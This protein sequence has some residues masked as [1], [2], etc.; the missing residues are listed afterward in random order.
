MN[1]NRILITPNYTDL[2]ISECPINCDT[3]EQIWKNEVFYLKI[4][5][6]CKKCN[7]K[8]NIVLDEPYKPSNTHCRNRILNQTADADDQI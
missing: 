6:E 2:V 8:K 7:H 1:T 4:I 3:C 5:C